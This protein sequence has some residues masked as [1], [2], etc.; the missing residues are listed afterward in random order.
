MIQYKQGTSEMSFGL[1]LMVGKNRTVKRNVDFK[2][3]MD[4]NKNLVLD[5]LYRYDEFRIR[6][7][8]HFSTCIFQINDPLYITK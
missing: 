6:S 1:Y 5:A 3:P 8:S 2:D 7:C 4:T